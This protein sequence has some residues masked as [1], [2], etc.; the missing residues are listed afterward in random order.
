MTETQAYY[1]YEVAAMRSAAVTSTV[2]YYRPTTTAHTPHTTDTVHY[3]K[4]NYSR[5]QGTKTVNLLGRGSVS[6]YF[7]TTDEFTVGSSAAL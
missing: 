2:Q 1:M 4:L 3:I 6:S 7:V 5:G